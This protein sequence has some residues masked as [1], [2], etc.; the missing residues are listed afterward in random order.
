MLKISNSP[1]SVSKKGSLSLKTYA[2]VGGLVVGS[3]SI[4]GDYNLYTTFLATF[5]SGHGLTSGDSNVGTLSIVVENVTQ[6]YTERTSVA[7][8]T[9]VV[10]G[11]NVF[12]R[13]GATTADM[14]YENMGLTNPSS[15]D[16]IKLRIVPNLFGYKAKASFT[17]T[18]LLS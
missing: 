16:T 8:Q 15:G 13:T 1:S 17:Q 4:N 18:V 14:T 12:F 10:A 5:P 6:G 11:N 3:S 2:K 9:F 7:L